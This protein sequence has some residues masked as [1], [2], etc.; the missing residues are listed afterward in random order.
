MFSLEIPANS[1]FAW[2][3]PVS[4][5]M[6]NF[7]VPSHSPGWQI[8]SSPGLLPLKPWPPP[9]QPSAE[10]LSITVTF[11]VV[12][13]GYME[14]YASPAP[15]VGAGS[16]PLHREVTKSH[17]R[18][19][20]ISAIS[21]AMRECSVTLAMLRIYQMLREAWAHPIVTAPGGFASSALTDLS[22][23]CES[24]TFLRAFNFAN[25][26]CSWGWPQPHTLQNWQP[27]Y[28]AAIL[29]PPKRKLLNMTV[30]CRD[31]Y[32]VKKS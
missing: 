28:E 32:C 8:I 16:F 27:Y 21:L 22:C 14:I 7:Y 31:L 2:L 3:I 24:Q 15:T 29:T 20:F 25:S 12:P 19:L 26:R 4:Y 18:L 11:T 13:S 10:F 30:L 1:L 23:L 6:P 9:S 17:R 5:S